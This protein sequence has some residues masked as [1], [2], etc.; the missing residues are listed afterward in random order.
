MKLKCK[1]RLWDGQITIDVENGSQIEEDK[2]GYIGHNYGSYPEDLHF[3]RIL[4]D[5]IKFILDNDVECEIEMVDEFDIDE[6]I[7]SDYIDSSD[8][9]PKLHKGKVIIYLK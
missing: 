6:D 7:S 4:K 3:E 9:T 5:D 1:F 2:I 8:L